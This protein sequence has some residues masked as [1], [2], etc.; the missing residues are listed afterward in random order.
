MP[1]ELDESLRDAYAELL[2]ARVP[3]YVSRRLRWAGGEA[4]VVDV[5]EGSPL[6]LLHGGMGQLLQWLPLMPAL[7]RSHRVIAVDRPGQGLSDPFPYD[8]SVNVLDHATE[9]LH[10]IL[11]G[12]GLQKATLV[13]NSMGGLWSV[14]FALRH[15]DRVEQ[16]VLVGAPAGSKRWIPRPARLFRIPLLR[17]LVR[18][19]ISR[20]GVQA[21]RD[22]FGR[23]LVAHPE[24]LDA[25]L[26][27]GM[28]LATRR[29]LD[30]TWGLWESV[31]TPW[32]FL[33]PHVVIG[34]GWREL[35]VPVTFGWGEKDVFDTPE[36]GEELA[37]LVPA[38]GRLLRVP[39][40][41]H[42]PWLDDPARV[43]EH[44]LSA[45]AAPASAAA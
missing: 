6:L 7:A 37:R 35:A 42:L 10:G 27:A 44:V 8:A 3:G 30:S 40:A 34:D 14:A 31:L 36:H 38:G 5:G 41:G 43:A 25:D 17:S 12:L 19:A 2:G 26:I 9:F 28:A 4:N 1:H 21:T 11:D 15:P 18:A 13:G 24:R 22:A 33:R 23:I 39:D 32:G 29:N 20:G 45:V 16:L